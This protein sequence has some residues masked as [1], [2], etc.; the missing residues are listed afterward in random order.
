M[1]NKR[2]LFLAASPWDK[3]RIGFDAEY[4]KIKQT[5][6]QSNLREKFEFELSLSVKIEDIQQEIIQFKPHVIH[7]SGHGK[8]G[9]LA[10]SNAEENIEWIDIETLRGLFEIIATHVEC[11]VLNACYSETQ[12]EIIAEHIDFVIGM[13]IKIGDV[14]A[15]KFSTGFYTAMFNGDDYETA[16]KQGKEAIRLAGLENQVDIPKLKIRRKTFVPSHKYDIAMSFASHDAEW[17]KNFSEYLQKQLNQKVFPVSSPLIYQGTE[18]ETLETAAMLL[19][20]ASPNYLEECNENKLDKLKTLS[21]QKPIFLIETDSYKIPES[22]KGL[23]RHKFWIDDEQQ[24]IIAL[25]GAA[26]TDKANQV[27]D[28]VAKQLHEL[29]AQHQ[30]QQRTEQQRQQQQKNRESN[31]NSIDAFIFLHSAPEDLNLTTE[32]AP[33]LEKNGVDYVLPVE[34]NDNLSASDIRQDIE[35]N[36]LNCDAVLILYDETSLIWVREQLGTC[37]RLQRKRETPLKIIAVHK[38]QH[39]PELN[40]QLENLQVYLCPPENIQSYLQ[41]FIEALA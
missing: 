6:R 40:Y 34:R 18:F 32:I 14:A 9:A 7:F 4:R 28:L 12:A 19:I 31:A 22:L 15:E 38:N 1:E 20:I 21:K 41:K 36:I 2:V 13:E 17:T 11:V 8:D 30:H 37:R 27:A 23:S 24:G 5:L 26:Y 33:L 35:N 10:F 25:Q 3:D 29:K 39:K 16:Y